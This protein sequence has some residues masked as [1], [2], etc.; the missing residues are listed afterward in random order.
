MATDT[1]EGQLAEEDPVEFFIRD[2]TLHGKSERT[3]RA[4]ERVVRR[5]E[6]FLET[7]R[8]RSLRGANRRDCME[9]VHSIRAESAPSTVATYASYLN[10]FYRYMNR[11]D[12]FEDNPMGLVVE[13][14]DESIDV[15]PE[16]RDVSLPMMREFVATIAHPL[17]RALVITFLKTGIRIGELCNLDL[18]DVHLDDPDVR[19]VY[20][21]PPRGALSDR[22][23]SLFVPA[24]PSQG[25]TYNGERRRASNKRQRSTVIPIDTELKG[26]LKRW[27]AIRPDARSAAEPLFCS[28]SE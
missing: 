26:T 14:M 28:T 15:N 10:R 2:L 19:R 9:W 16:R 8:G 18:R 6:S 7:E 5:F 24:E 11:V 21:I 25:S 23:D 22:P 12:V 17:D 3:R 1:P 4:Y 13:E 27:L 20:D